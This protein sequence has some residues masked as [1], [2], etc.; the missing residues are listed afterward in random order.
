MGN[1]DVVSIAK[2]GSGK[3]LAFLLP[4]YHKMDMMRGGRGVKILVLAPTRELATQIH[5][6]AGKFGGASGYSSAC[7]YGGAPKRE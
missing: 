5:D 3:T 7:A 2:T 6:E 4:A 1:R